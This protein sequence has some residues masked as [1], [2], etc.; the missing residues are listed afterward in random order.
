MHRQHIFGTN[1]SNYMKQLLEDDEDAYKRQFSRYIKH[2]ITPDMVCLFLLPLPWTE[3][4]FFTPI[5]P[6]SVSRI[7]LKV[8]DRFGQFGLD[9]LCV[10]VARMN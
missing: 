3:V 5:K 1:I 2:S 4:V 8:V 9:R 6:V 7:Y 10:C